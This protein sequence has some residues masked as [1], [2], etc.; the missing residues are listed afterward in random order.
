[1]ARLD[2][3]SPARFEE[4]YGSAEGVNH[5]IQANQSLELQVSTNSN[6]SFSLKMRDMTRSSATAEKLRDALC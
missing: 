6:N 1:M 2:A 5:K 4:W 3:E